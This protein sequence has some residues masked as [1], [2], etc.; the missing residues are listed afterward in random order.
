MIDAIH[1]AELAE[2]SVQKQ[3]AEN[4]FV[5]VDAVRA[6]T[7]EE[8]SAECVGENLPRIEVPIGSMSQ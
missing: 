8:A 7:R 3:A 1:Q 4:W 6:A 2:L 5:P